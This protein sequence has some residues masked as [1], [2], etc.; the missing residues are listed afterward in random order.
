[1]VSLRLIITGMKNGSK[2]S[3]KCIPDFKLTPPELWNEHLAPYY[4]I[5]QV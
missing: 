4:H 3:Q 1:M 5:V 2:K